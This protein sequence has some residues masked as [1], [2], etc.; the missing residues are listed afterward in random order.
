ME[1]LRQRELSA[2][3]RFL[4]DLYAVRNLG[5]FRT[6][7]L[8]ALPALVGADYVSYNEANP[9]IRRNAYVSAPVVPAAYEL[10]FLQHMRDHPLISH[11]QETGDGR[12][13]RISDVLPQRRFRRLALYNEF[14]RPL[15]TEYQ[16]AVTVP[17]PAPL[18]VGIA[19]SR[20]G[21]DFSGRERRLLDLLRPHLI[22]A[23]RNAEQVTRMRE[24]HAAARRALD[25]LRSGVV[26]LTRDGRIR[27]VNPA[28][29]RML[30]G[31]YGRPLRHGDRLPE[32]LERWV[33]HHAAAGEAPETPRAPLVIERGEHDLIVRRA[34]GGDDRLLILE[35]QTRALSHRGILPLGLTR[36]EADVM[37]WVVRGKTNAE[38]AAVLGTSPYTVIKH[39]QHVFAKLD[40]RTR[41]AAAARVLTILGSPPG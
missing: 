28:A 9:R 23:Y 37:M 16:I 33:R 38:I 35:E 32:E 6:Y 20:G 24:E 3:A 31:C 27:L 7:L 30:T 1:S 25:Q 17:A 10:A 5:E 21:K 18:V 34:G 29:V 2:A 11:Y 8:S 26:V 4:R 39:L 22:Q 36:R 41:T 40:V 15:R 19:L 13:L 14:Y 12:A